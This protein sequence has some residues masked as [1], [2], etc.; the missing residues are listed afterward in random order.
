M[1]EKFVEELQK[2]SVE[3]RKSSIDNMLKLKKQKEERLR[4]LLLMTESEINTLRM[5]QKE[6]EE[7]LLKKG[8]QDDT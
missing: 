2:Q 1:L 5:L 7:A 4:S 8:E 6:Y 3:T